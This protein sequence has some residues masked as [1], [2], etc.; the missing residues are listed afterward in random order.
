M[1]GLKQ[2][3]LKST[4]DHAISI[5]LATITSNDR[6]DLIMGRN[7]NIENELATLIL[8][9]NNHSMRIN[10]RVVDRITDESILST[11]NDF[12]S[13]VNPTDGYA[14]ETLLPLSKACSPLMNILYNLSFYV[15]MALDE[16]PEHP[17][18]GLTIDEKPPFK[19][20]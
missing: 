19:G 6:V 5:E 2:N 16:T 10:H 4:N 3:P 7:V 15:Q 9:D 18:D 13:N 12:K 20:I 11:M 1:F 8:N 17:S 14:E